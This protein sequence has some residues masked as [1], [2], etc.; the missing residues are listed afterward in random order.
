MKVRRFRGK[1]HKRGISLLESLMLVTILG[2][3]SAGAG[4]VLIAIGKI[5]G[6]TETTLKDE[7][8]MVSKLEQIRATDYDSL[9]IGTAVSPFSDGGVSV[10]IAYT[11]PH[12][13]SSPSTNWKQITV[14]LANGRQ[15]VALV[16]KP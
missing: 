1:P 13:G 7:T 5:P 11:D 16:C 2:I 12:G 9:T 15:L 4:Q 3:I 8:S 10:D 14:R 6:Q